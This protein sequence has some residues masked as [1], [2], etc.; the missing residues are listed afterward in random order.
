MKSEVRSF[1]QTCLWRDWYAWYPVF[2]QGDGIFW[3]EYL[4]C[5]KSEK[6]GWEYR[7]LRLP[8]DKEQEETRREI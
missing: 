3:L 5:R 1:S 8:G 6:K 4:R 2:A 7:A